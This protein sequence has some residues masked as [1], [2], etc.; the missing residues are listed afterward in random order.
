MSELWNNVEGPNVEIIG[1]VDKS[2]GEVKLRCSC[3]RK[4]S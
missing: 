2:R 4:L 3:N 1:N